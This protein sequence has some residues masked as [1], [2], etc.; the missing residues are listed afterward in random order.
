MSESYENK[1]GPFKSQI[2]PTTFQDVSPVPFQLS[3]ETKEL[4]T[5]RFE[6][7]LQRSNLSPLRKTPLKKEKPIVF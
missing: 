1:V 5:T 4:S 7:L 6:R 2:K 3:A